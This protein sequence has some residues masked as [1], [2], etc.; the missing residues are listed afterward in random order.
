MAIQLARDGRRVLW[1][2][3]ESAPKN[4]TRI[5]VTGPAQPSVI[6]QTDLPH[7]ECGPTTFDLVG[8]LLV[9][10]TRRAVGLKPPASSSSTCPTRASPSRSRSST[11]PERIPE[12]CTTLVRRRRLPAPGERQRPTSKSPNPK[13]DQFYRIN[14]RPAGPRPVESGAG[15]C[16]APGRGRGAAAGAFTRSST[17]GSAPTHERLS[18]RP[19]RAL[20]R[21]H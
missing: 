11:P 5:D 4:F 1:R 18:R 8:D 14:R 9:V 12:V 21:L 20:D 10:R 7:G 19:D 17:P 13:D 3:H 16:P 2:V 6:V 15:G